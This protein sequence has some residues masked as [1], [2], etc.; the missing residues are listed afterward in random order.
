MEHFNEW[1]KSNKGME[2]RSA[3]DVQSRIKRVQGLMQRNQIDEN[4]LTILEDNEG[5][6]KLSITVKSQL[7]RSVRLYLEF[8]K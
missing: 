6:R 7:R 4:T 2:L 3:R 1:L 8:I 5:F